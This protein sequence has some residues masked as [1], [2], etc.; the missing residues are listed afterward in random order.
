MGQSC[1]KDP[2]GSHSALC[3]SRKEAGDGRAVADL[4]TR[5][6]AL[7]IPDSPSDLISSRGTWD[8]QQAKWG[9]G[10][11]DSSLESV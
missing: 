8:Q 3:C 1:G 6:K 2:N 10:L 5:I 7:G 9:R 11:K 4:Q